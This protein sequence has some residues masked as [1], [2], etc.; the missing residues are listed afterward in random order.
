VVHQAYSAPLP[1]IHSTYVGH[2]IYCGSLDNLTKEHI[3]PSGAGGKYTLVD[4]PCDAC[5]KIT[6]KFEQDCLKRWFGPMRVRLGLASRRRPKSQRP[7]SIE[8]TTRNRNTGKPT[9]RLMS[10]ND[11]PAPLTGM[12]FDHPGILTGSRPTNYSGE[13]WG[14]INVDIMPNNRSRATN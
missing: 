10:K 1:Q 5:A 9:S 4:G 13:F 14:A 12:I 8:L 2:C 11:H 3:I 6:T 7:T